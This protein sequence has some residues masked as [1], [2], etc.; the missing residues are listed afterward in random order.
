[1]FINSF[2]LNQ[3]FPRFG[4]GLLFWDEIRHQPTDHDL[5]NCQCGQDYTLTL[6]EQGNKGLM[7]IQKANIKVKDRLWFSIDDELN[8][9]QVEAAEYYLDPDDMGMLLLKKV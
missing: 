6:M 1:M 9:Y 2:S 4:T 8:C 7:T 3:L 5:S